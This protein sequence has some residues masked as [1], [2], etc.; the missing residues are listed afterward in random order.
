MGESTLIQ[1]RSSPRLRD[2]DYKGSYA[3]FITCCTNQKKPHFK[4]KDIVGIMVDVLKETSQRFNFRVYAYCF[5]PD[6][7][8]LLVTGGE[9]SSLGEFMRFFKQKTSFMFKKREGNSL[10]QRSYYNHVLRKEETLRDVAL[11]IFH[12]PVRKK[13]VE[14]YQDYPFSGSFVFDKNELGK[15]M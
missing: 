15:S 2:F 13:L 4:D 3:Y 8:H 7:L 1:R 14:N 5:M 12:N 10:W 9:T 11:Y 6:H